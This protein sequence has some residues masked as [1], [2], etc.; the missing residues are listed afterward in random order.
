MIGKDNMDGRQKG[1]LIVGYRKRTISC[2]EEG[3]ILNK[4]KVLLTFKRLK[5]SKKENNKSEK[6][7]DGDYL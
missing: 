3:S 4:I 2:T 7:V 6:N 5:N 1:K